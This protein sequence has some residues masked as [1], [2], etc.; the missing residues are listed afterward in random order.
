MALLFFLVLLI[1]LTTLLS[2]LI[3]K[4]RRKEPIGTNWF[5]EIDADHPLYVTAAVPI[6]FWTFIVGLI[7]LTIAYF[8]IIA[9]VDH[10]TRWW[11]IV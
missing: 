2:H 1:V 7:W 9:I 5:T 11:S 10:L 6:F 4:I 3:G 8:I